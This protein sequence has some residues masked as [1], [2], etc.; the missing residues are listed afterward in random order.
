[1]QWIK[2]CISHKAYISLYSGL[3]CVVGRDR[4]GVPELQ[5]FQQCAKL[6]GVARCVGLEIV[7]EKGI[8]RAAF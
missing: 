6:F 5:D 7:I 3:G 1:M 4:H 2:T 8:E